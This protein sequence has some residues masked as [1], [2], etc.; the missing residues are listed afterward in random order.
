VHL[1]SFLFIVVIKYNVGI[2]TDDIRF[3]RR[4]VNIGKVVKSFK[5]GQKENMIISHPKF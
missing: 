5:G 3:V 4:F 1:V 2:F